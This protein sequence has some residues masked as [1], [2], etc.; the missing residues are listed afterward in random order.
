VNTTSRGM[1]GEDRPRPRA[2]WV[3]AITALVDRAPVRPWWVYLALF[4]FLF[5]A[6]AVSAW[7]GGSLEPSSLLSLHFLTAAW[8]VFPLALIHY[9][10][11]VSHRALN[12]FRPVCD[13]D[14]AEASRLASALTTMPPLPAALAGAAGAA[15]IWIVY[16]TNDELFDP[17]RATAAQF[18]V[19]MAVLS[20]SFAMLGVLLYHTVRQLGLVSAIYGRVRHLDL[21]NLSPLYGF[22]ALASQTAMAWAIAL[23]LSLAF[24]PDI[25]GSGIALGAFV[26][27]VALVLA[28][29]TWPL[30]GIHRQIREKKERAMA[31]LGESLNRAIRELSAR[32]RSMSLG[33]VDGLNK[34]V[35]S[36]V[37]A[38]DV[39]SR[40][41]TWPWSPGTPIAVASAL[42]LPV[43]L[44]VVQRVLERLIGS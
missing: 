20:F 4:S 9:L 30:V 3:D 33:E 38:R 41:P 1:E 8:A 6:L 32:A 42:L 14:D 2:S 27:Q 25:L 35:S 16:L 37:S 17:I 36:L 12:Q 29:F 22:A 10:D 19:G 28:T 15:F 44:F 13:L 18:A 11:R 5:A 39:L 43:G 34:L 26:L 24:N 21:F 40:V 31:E 23:Y 7:M